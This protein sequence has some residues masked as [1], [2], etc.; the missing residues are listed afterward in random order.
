MDKLLA[1]MGLGMVMVTILVTISGLGVIIFH[2]V[3][4]HVKAKKEQ[5]NPTS[6]VHEVKGTVGMKYVCCPRA[7]AAAPV[8][9]VPYNELEWAR[10]TG[11]CELMVQINCADGYIFAE[12]V[13][14]QIFDAVRPGTKMTVTYSLNTKTNERKCISLKRHE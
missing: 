4:D 6:S 7:S 13:S 8:I 9:R 1:Q 14:P 11:E 3:R 12:W 10:K 5:K 2:L